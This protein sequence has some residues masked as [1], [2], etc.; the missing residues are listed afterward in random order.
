MYVDVTNVIVKPLVYSVYEPPSVLAIEATRVVALPKS[1]QDLKE[2]HVSLPVLLRHRTTVFV[3]ALFFE[4]KVATAVAPEG[5]EQHKVDL[6][7][8]PFVEGSAEVFSYPKDHPVVLVDALDASGVVL[9]PLHRRLLAAH[10]SM[11]ALTGY[12]SH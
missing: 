3:H 6:A 2:T 11:F 9:A 5:V 10:I 7:P 12:L 1:R 8:V 4:V